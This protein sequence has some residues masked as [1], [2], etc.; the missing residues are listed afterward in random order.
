[1]PSMLIDKEA[2]LRKLDRIPDLPTLPVV[3]FKVNKMLMDDDVNVRKLS[4]TIEK[5][6]AMV[7]KLLRLVNS[8]FYGFQSKID[9]ISHAITILGFSTVRNAVVSISVVDA[10][11]GR[12][13]FEEFSLSDFWK[14]SVAVA[15]T[16]RQLAQRSR[17]A[18]PDEVFVAGIL[19]D[20]GKLVLAQHYQELFRDVWIAVQD[21]GLS[22]HEA[23]KALLPVDHAH[24][25]GVLAAKWHLPEK[26]VE[27]IAY[28]HAVGTAENNGNAVM[29]VS[30]ADFLV[31]RFWSEKKAGDRPE[32]DQPAAEALAAEIESADQ[33]FPGVAAEI[34]QACSFFV[35]A[36]N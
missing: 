15:V 19:H 35:E 14:H 10:F 9:N 32:P 22:F 34:E 16:G 31:H 23:E 3:A 5:D 21:E 26:L 12:E 8:A 27:A 29:T 7:S 13:A 2:F 18:V 20:V 25:G 33:W 11:S 17:L 28:H 24:I 6:Q 1:M 4:E 30:A 36:V